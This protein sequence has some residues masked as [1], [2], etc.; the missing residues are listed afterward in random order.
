MASRR[1]QKDAALQHKRADVLQRTADVEAAERRALTEFV[2]AEQGA[3]EAIL[4]RQLCQAQ[5]QLRQ[6]AVN[7]STAEHETAALAQDN[8]SLYKKVGV[9][10]TDR[11]AW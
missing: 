10:V 9:F 7:I 4:R 11:C 2:T 3:E 8:S 5:L 6:A 1:A